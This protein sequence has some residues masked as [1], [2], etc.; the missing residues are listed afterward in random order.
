MASRSQSRRVETSGFFHFAL[1]LY[2][3]LSI[4]LSLFPQMHR[5]RHRQESSQK[6]LI[7]RGRGSLFRLTPF[8][9]YQFDIT[10]MIVCR[11]VRDP[12]PRDD[13]VEDP[14]RT[15]VSC[16]LC[17]PLS[18]F[19]LRCS[20]A[21]LFVFS[22]FSFLFLRQQLFPHRAIKL[23]TFMKNPSPLSFS[24]SLSLTLVHFPGLAYTIPRDKRKRISPKRKRKHSAKSRSSESRFFSFTRRGGGGGKLKNTRRTLESTM[25]RQMPDD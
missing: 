20:Y 9:S 6:T 24:L 19:F 3:S 1:S 22:F 10:I 23:Y 17:P 13:Q 14:C 2:R 5:A 16:A 18:L 8:R 12:W 11:S 7:Q 15:S 4:S 25:A 21:R